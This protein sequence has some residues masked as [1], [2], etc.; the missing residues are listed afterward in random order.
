[1]VDKAM[2]DSMK[3]GAILINIARGP[4]V[5]SAAIIAALKEG[6]LAGIAMDV[7]DHHPLNGKEEVFNAPNL[8]LTPHIASITA[9]S[10]QKMSEG[11]VDTLL[12]IFEGQRP[13]I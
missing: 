2:I 12:K 4:I 8:L 6:R 9:T 10:L 3:P 5:D 13:L 11:S 7:H 1:M